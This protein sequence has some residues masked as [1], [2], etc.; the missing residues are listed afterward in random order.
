MPMIQ[1]PKEDGYMPFLFIYKYLLPI[2]INEGVI[3]LGI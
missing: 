3:Q 1:M 2:E